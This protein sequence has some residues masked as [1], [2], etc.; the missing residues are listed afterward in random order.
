MRHARVC[1][2]GCEGWSVTGTTLVTAA[3]WGLG[4]PVIHIVLGATVTAG[5]AF[6]RHGRI[7]S[8][9]QPVY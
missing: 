2:R 3:D 9:L 4:H 7:A 5:V 1:D 8:L 6:V